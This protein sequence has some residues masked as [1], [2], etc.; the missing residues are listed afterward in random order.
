[1]P[2]NS[3][4][5]KTGPAAHFL[6]THPIALSDGQNETV[7]M[8]ARQL[9]PTDEDSSILTIGIERL[10][11]NTSVPLRVGHPTLRGFRDL[12]RLGTRVC[13]QLFVCPDRY[14]PSQ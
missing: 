4:T 12:N 14:L 13:G 8:T 10:S 3:K 11:E 5:P 1:M 6:L 2:D 9:M 7:L